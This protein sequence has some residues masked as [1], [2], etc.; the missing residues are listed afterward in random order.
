[1]DFACWV[2]NDEIISNV[3]A[4]Y[5]STKKTLTLADPNGAI[6]LGKLRDLYYGNS[7][8][9]QN[10]CVG[11][12]GH[13]KQFYKAKGGNTPDFDTTAPVTITLENNQPGAHP[14]IDLTITL[15][16]AS[17]VNIAWNYTAKPD[18]VK[19]PYAVP[20]SIVSIDL[21]PGHRNLSDFITWRTRT[22][23]EDPGEFILTV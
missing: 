18:A 21:H 3:T 5:N 15:T 13:E 6:N 22:G 19:T 8:T 12:L 9:D 10:L 11:I 14:D 2:S 16:E 4:T 7:Q 23:A 17:M 1:M 20:Q